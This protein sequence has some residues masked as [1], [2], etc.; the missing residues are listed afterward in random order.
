MDIRHADAA[1]AERL[2]EMLTA[3]LGFEPPTLTHVRSRLSE[4][5]HSGSIT[6]V[7]E[8]EGEVIAFV[9]YVVF[10]SLEYARPQA[11]IT[12]IVVSEAGRHSGIGRGLV[13][14]VET[15]AALA[16]CFRVE[17]TSAHELPEAH[18]FWNSIGY[19]NAGLRYKRA[20]DPPSAG[21]DSS[22]R[23]PSRG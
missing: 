2:C 10:R 13:A 17:L 11:R 12:A 1:D 23:R 22:D 7:A 19:E 16:G 5:E 21:Q 3:G 14:A 18:R 6:L 8:R 4:G 9:T 20:I 15:E